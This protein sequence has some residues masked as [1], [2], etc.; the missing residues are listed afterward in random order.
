MGTAS[1]PEPP[2]GLTEITGRLDGLAEAIKQAW[3]PGT[4]ARPGGRRR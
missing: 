2:E 3:R 1:T 4:H